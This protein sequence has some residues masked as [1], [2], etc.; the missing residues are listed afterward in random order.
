MIRERTHLNTAGTEGASGGLR[1]QLFSP[2]TTWR[3]SQD[4]PRPTGP[5]HYRLDSS[6]RP[7]MIATNDG[8]TRIQAISA[9]P[10]PGRIDNPNLSLTCL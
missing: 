1:A 8:E 3:Q 2:V 10:H 5:E 4:P 7:G 6:P 9:Y